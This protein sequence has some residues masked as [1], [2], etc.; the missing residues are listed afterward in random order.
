MAEITCK[1]ASNTCGQ[2]FFVIVTTASTRCL[3]ENFQLISCSQ[4]VNATWQYV[5]SGS[6]IFLKWPNDWIVAVV[7]HCW[8]LVQGE[9]QSAH[10]TTK[11]PIQFELLLGSIFNF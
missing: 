7:K 4:Q 8:I 3:V 2:F 1:F 10:E 9:I 5:D 6:S 11:K